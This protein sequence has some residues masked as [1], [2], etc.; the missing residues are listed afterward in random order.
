MIYLHVVY[1]YMFLFISL[2]VRTLTSN[3]L[4]M[5]EEQLIYYSNLSNQCYYQSK[6][7]QKTDTTGN[8]NLNANIFRIV[9]TAVEF[10]SHLLDLLEHRRKA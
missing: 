3:H 1:L 10:Q 9:E 6:N 4:P 8:T 7:L 2:L 5:S